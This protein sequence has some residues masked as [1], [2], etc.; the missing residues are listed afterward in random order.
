MAHYR[1]GRAAIDLDR[2]VGVTPD[3]GPDD[4]P[5]GGSE[6]GDLPMGRTPGL[7]VHF[8]GTRTVRLEG[9]E[10]RA[11]AEYI[12]RLPPAEVAFEPGVSGEDHGPIAG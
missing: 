6:G 12:R 9:A 3:P 2:V 4:G 5:E 1:F 8:E 7:M 10:A 11:M